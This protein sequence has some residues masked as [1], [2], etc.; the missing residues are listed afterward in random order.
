MISE[1]ILA[2]A[3]YCSTS[4]GLLKTGDLIFEI[5]TEGE[6]SKAITDATSGN[7]SIRFSH[8]GIIEIDSG[9]NVSVI[10]ATGNNGVTVT[11]LELFMEKAKGGAVIKRLAIE[12]QI[13]ETLER[14]KSYIGR[15]YDWWYLP[16]NDEI[17]CSELVE[18]SYL[19]KD[20]TP[21]FAP[22][23]MNFRD[24]EGNMPK[25]WTELFNRLGR[26]VPE[27]MPGTNPQQISQYPELI[28]VC[29]LGM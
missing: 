1:L 23:L 7:D 9:S 18:K 19:K 17:Y 26:P 13:D 11:P 28:Y 10:E 2:S 12:Y 4:N 20:G 6:M 16:D 21:I 22:I 27:G 24:S 14:A 29:T 3:A 8:V 5:A 15:G 25:F